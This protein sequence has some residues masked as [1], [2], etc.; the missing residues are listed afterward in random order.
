L[1]PYEGGDMVLC[2]DLVSFGENSISPARPEYQN[3]GIPTSGSSNLPTYVREDMDNYRPITVAAQHLSL[4]RY[5]TMQGNGEKVSR[6]YCKS[7]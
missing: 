6:S 1:I 3:L 2:D 4:L 5:D 7:W